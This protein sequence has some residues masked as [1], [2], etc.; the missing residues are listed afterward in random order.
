MKHRPTIALL[1]LLGAVGLGWLQSAF[2]G[3]TATGNT[4]TWIVIAGYVQWTFLVLFVLLVLS[5][6]ANLVRRTFHDM[7]HGS[8]R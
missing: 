5:G 8:F 2:D 6:L 7:R 4:P 1:A 3:D